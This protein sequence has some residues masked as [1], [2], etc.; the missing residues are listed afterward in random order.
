MVAVRKKCGWNE[1]FFLLF[2]F[3]LEAACHGRWTIMG[4]TP[5]VNMYFVPCLVK[6]PNISSS[7]IIHATLY[8]C[9]CVH[10]YVL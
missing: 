5:M 1:L 3:I 10:V 8:L 9:A 6:E 4:F 7:Y 2:F